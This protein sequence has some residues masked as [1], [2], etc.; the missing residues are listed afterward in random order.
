MVFPTSDGKSELVSATRELHLQ[1]A[2][3]ESALSALQV[4]LATE[5]AKA[6]NLPNP[7]TRVN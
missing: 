5:R 3:L 2:K 1:V 6:I 7:L 4:T